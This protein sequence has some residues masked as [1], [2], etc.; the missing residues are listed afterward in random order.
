[1]HASE[2]SYHHGD[3]AGALVRAAVELLEEGGVTELSL[4]AAA[5]RAGVSA[6][7]PYRHFADREALVSAVAA[8]GYRDLAAQLAAAHAAPSTVD[9]LAEVAIAY[10]RFA[11]SRPGLFRA[12]FAE[13]RDPSTAERAAAVEAVREYL[14]SIVRQ[15]LPSDDPDSMALA[16]WGLVHGLAFLHLDGRLDSSSADDVADRV[17]AVV[18]AVLGRS[19]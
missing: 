14:D 17:R 8:V 6:G 12:M 3:L 18:R 4:R 5:R 7:A 2:R 1:M 9:D 16:M 11:L 15:A 13:P 19:P 10:V